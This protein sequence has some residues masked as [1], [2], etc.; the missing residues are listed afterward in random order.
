[1]L[2]LV[3]KQI[4]GF[5]NLSIGYEQLHVVLGAD[6]EMRRASEGTLKGSISKLSPSNCSHSNV[7]H[8]PTLNHMN[9]SSIKIFPKVA[10]GLGG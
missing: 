4:P 9:C 2:G 10:I 1:M 3:R 7:N 6:T 5:V 8:Q